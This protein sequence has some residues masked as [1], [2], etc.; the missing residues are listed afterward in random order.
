MEAF[1]FFFFGEKGDKNDSDVVTNDVVR[2]NMLKNEFFS[3]NI[4]YHNQ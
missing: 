2:E 4:T 3:N 1:N